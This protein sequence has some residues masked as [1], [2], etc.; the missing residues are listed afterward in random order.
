MALTL[1]RS[2]GGSIAA[3]L[4][5]LA[6]LAVFC[7][8]F[9]VASKNPGDSGES[10]ILLV[11]FAMPWVSIMPTEWLGLGAGLGSI[12]LNS[13]ILYCI[14]GGLRKRTPAS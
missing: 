9:F 12:L 11:P 5:L 7:W 2:R 8:V 6:A 10:G 3:G 13:I 14:F 1:K 4:F